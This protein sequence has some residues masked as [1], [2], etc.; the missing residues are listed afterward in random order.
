MPNIMLN[1]QYKCMIHNYII[2]ILTKDTA[3]TVV[4]EMDS[5]APGIHDPSVLTMQQ[6]H[7]STPLW[8]AQVRCPIVM[9]CILLMI[10]YDLFKCLY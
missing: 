10:T 2:V 8:D 5:A 7:G 4:K 9:I 6:E 3:N 1:L